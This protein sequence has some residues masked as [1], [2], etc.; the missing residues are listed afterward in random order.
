[1]EFAAKRSAAGVSRRTERAGGDEARVEPPKA[2]ER[3]VSAD[4]ALMIIT[5]GTANLD[6]T[7]SITVELIALRP[8]KTG[9]MIALADI[10]LG[11]DGVEFVIHGVQ[12]NRATDAGKEATKVTLPTYRNERGAWTAAISLPIELREP[13]ARIVLESCIEAGLCRR[14]EGTVDQG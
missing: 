6:D 8:V 10:R 13:M 12:V 7:T 5:D 14:V 2:A 9:R 4:S 1:L 3:R 11:V